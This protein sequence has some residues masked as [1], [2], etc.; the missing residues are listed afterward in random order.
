[1]ADDYSALSKRSFEEYQPPMFAKAPVSN[2][3][4]FSDNIHES[5]S[6]MYT[7]DELFLEEEGAFE[8]KSKN[9]G[10]SGN[11]MMNDDGSDDEDDGSDDEDD[12]DDTRRKKSRGGSN[13]NISE[14]QKV[15]RRFVNLFHRDILFY[16]ECHLS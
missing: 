1:M 16:T 9:N 12:E 5:G 11:I 3:P 2:Q 7:M 15:E 13:R 4:R 10:N 8:V 6:L 14:T